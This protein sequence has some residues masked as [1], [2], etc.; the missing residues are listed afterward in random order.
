MAERVRFGLKNVHYAVLTEGTTPSWGT[1]K[2][3]PGAVS[4]SLSQEGSRDPF[5]AD[6][7]TY[8]MT[9][10]NN[11]YSGD[12]EMA[13]IPDSMMVDVFG[14]TINEDGVAT[15]NANAEHK[16]FALLFQIE[17]DETNKKYVLYRCFASRPNIN[18]QT[19]E[20]TI[21]PQTQ[22]LN[23][24]ALPVVGGPQDGVVKRSTTDTID[25]EVDAAWF[26]AVYTG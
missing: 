4:L 2:A 24:S 17:N 18:S 3:I 13:I 26:T 1:P 21:T 10:S 22:T 23:F 5:Y 20:Q 25:S 14:E 6:N 7:T 12:I 8:F 9:D 15:E 16:P 19:K 11:G